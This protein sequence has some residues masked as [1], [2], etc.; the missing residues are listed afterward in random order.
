LGSTLKAQITAY[1]NGT[2]P[3][4]AAIDAALNGPAGN[5]GTGSLL[6]QVTTSLTGYAGSVGNT[7]F[8]GDVTNLAN[9]TVN[10]DSPA[11]VSTSSL[12]G[13]DSGDDGTG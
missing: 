13:P 4:S 12:F 1:L 11:P 10:N 2:G 3:D 8:G 6:D 9:T 5:G 7:T